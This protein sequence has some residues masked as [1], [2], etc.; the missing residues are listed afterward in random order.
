[1]STNKQNLKSR[2]VTADYSVA[3]NGGTAGATS[4]YDLGIKIPAGAI[5]S[6]VIVKGT[7]Q[8]SG[9][10]TNTMMVL[11]VGNSTTHASN[12]DIS[13]TCYPTAVTTGSVVTVTAPKVISTAGNLRFAVKGTATTNDITAAVL[14]FYVTYLISQ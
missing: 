1:M 5:I 13:T 12:T 11:Q 3:A 7:T 9:T 2:T 10:T 14:T 8:A 4:A 6:S